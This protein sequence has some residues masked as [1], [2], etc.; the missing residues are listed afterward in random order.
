MRSWG[1]KT[2]QGRKSWKGFSSIPKYYGMSCPT[3]T[4]TRPWWERTELTSVIS[5]LEF[6]LSNT[7]QICWKRNGTGWGTKEKRTLASRS[8]GR[9][10]WTKR[11]SWR[12]FGSTRPEVESSKKA[13]TSLPAPKTQKLRGPIECMSFMANFIINIPDRAIS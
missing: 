12:S 13:L 4:G 9:I 7:Y 6:S 1:K 11:T 5:C 10:G 2:G 3:W 8:T